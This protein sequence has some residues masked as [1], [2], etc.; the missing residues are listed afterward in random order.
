VTSTRDELI[1]AVV[2]LMAL[3]SACASTPAEQR[4][5][6]PAAGTPV[7]ELVNFGSLGGSTTTCQFSGKACRAWVVAVDGK[8]TPAFSK[9][10]LVVPGVHKVLV[11]CY[12]WSAPPKIVGYIPKAGPVV[13][14][15]NAV[16]EFVALTGPFADNRKYYIRCESEAGKPRISIAA[17][18]EGS[19]LLGFE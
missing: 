4:Y 18:P 11:G 6:A 9:T 17:S 8:Y 3:C 12:L 14:G 15:G 13:E 5:Q 19:A 2:T 16:P 7:A 10:T 1:V